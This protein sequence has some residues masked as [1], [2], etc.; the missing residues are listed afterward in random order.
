[1][2]RCKK[3]V[4]NVKTIL[5]TGGS[6]FIGRNLLE[7]ELADKY[8]IIAPS[9]HEL[10]LED[11]ECVDNYFKDKSFDVVLHSAIKPGHRNAKDLSNLF[12]T[13]IRIFENLERNKEKF[14]KFINFGSGAIYDMM[15]N[16]FNVKEDEI[17]QRMGKDEH[18][19]CK[20]V[21]HKQ[22]DKLDNFMDLNIFGIFGKY[23]DYAIRFI[24][25]ACCKALFDLPI[26]LR[27]N[28][29]FSYLDVT[30]LPFILECLIENKTQYKTYNIAP[31]NYVELKNLAEL[32]RKIS[33]K[34]VDINI[35][36]DGY[37]LD[38]YGSNQRLK[39]EFPQIKFT[40]IEQSIANLYR[41]YEQNKDLIDFNQLL[42]DK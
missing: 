1:M 17:Y 15:D 21:M 7:S 36:K 22:I 38:Y 2:I 18:S 29:R 5:L 41:Y 11:T 19:F 40:P 31:D 25:N 27:Q 9:H 8:Q 4:Y 14:D 32:V 26:T 37:G 35:A 23:E 33:G 30:D 20:Y 28:R 3:G 12:Y 39:R 13:N 6:G 24:S 34:N 16:N 42:E 10:P